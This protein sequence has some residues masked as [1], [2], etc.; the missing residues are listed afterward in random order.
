[1]NDSDPLPNINNNLHNLEKGELFSCLDLKQDFHQI[2]LT[3]DSKALTAIVT[4]EGL[5]EHNILSMGLKD[6]PMSFCRIIN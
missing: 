1:M 2:P 6:S 5:Y 3:E 4:L